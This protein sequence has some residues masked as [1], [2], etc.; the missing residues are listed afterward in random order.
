M[1]PLFFMLSFFLSIA[2][3]DPDIAR[4]YRPF[5]ILYKDGHVKRLMGNDFVPASLDPKTN[6]KSKDIVYSPQYNLS[7]RIYFSDSNNTIKQKLPLLVYF[8]GGGFISFNP[9]SD[10]Y[11]EYLNTLV[12]EGKI[13]AV[14]VQYRRAPENPIPGAFEDSWTALEWIASH[15]KGKGPEDLLNTYADFQKVILSGDSAGATIAHRMGIRQ[16]QEKLDGFNIDGISLH[17]PYFWGT[18]PVAGETTKGPERAGVDDLWRIASPNTTGSDDPL[19]NPVTDPKFSSLECS[20][21]LVIVAEIDILK[22]RGYYYIEKLKESG[23]KGK[24]EILE[25]KGEDH[26]FNIRNSTSENSVKMLRRAVS[27]IN[28]T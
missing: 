3:A 1:A 8:H 12:S 4:E 27:F 25:F 21:V 22:A 28:G 23:W 19:I 24:A 11:H 10:K 7:C 2:S 17:F 20:R 9:F 5:F 13:I 14:S 26:A 16:S 15:T 6:V 18:K